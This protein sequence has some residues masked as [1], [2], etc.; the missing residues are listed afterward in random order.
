MALKKHLFLQLAMKILKFI[1]IILATQLIFN[2]C[3]KKLDLYDKNS[4]LE[5]KW[6]YVFSLVSYQD[7]N[8]NIHSDTLIDSRNFYVEFLKKGKIYFL[9][10]D[11]KIKSLKI[12]DYSYQIDNNDEIFQFKTC[13][14]YETFSLGSKVRLSSNEFPFPLYYESEKKYSNVILYNNYF[15]K[16]N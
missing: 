7:N 6:Q 16:I 3:K 5:G 11:N 9:M 2:S 8:W 10:E 4:V 12:I 1:L 13:D 15:I 14:T